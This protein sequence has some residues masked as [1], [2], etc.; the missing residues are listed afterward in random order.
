M[1]RQFIIVLECGVEFSL[2][3]LFLLQSESG[4]IF[5]EDLTWDLLFFAV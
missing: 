5:S 2:V 3:F 1:M 4:H